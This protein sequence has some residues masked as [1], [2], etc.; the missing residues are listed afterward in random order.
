M[1]ADTST[2][3][4]ETY[5][6]LWVS[7]FFHDFPHV[8]FTF[9]IV[10]STFDPNSDVYRQSLLFWALVPVAI[11][12]LLWLV[13][14]IYFIFRC[15]QG[16]RKSKGRPSVCQG[17]AD[18]TSY[19]HWLVSIVLG[20]VGFG[21]YENENAHHGI[22]DV[23]DSRDDVNDVLQSASNR[24]DTLKIL[25][26]DVL[27][28][29][30]GSLET[31]ANN[32]TNASVRAL[33]VRL[34]SDIRQKTYD[35]RGYLD[36]VRVEEARDSSLDTIFDYEYFRWMITIVIFCLYIFILLL[37][38]VGL[39][40]RSKG[41]LI[42]S[43]AVAVVCSLFIWLATGVYT[44]LSVAAGDLCMDPDT[45]FIRI[46][47]GSTAEVAVTAYIRC[48]DPNQ[49]YKQIIDNAT[50][51]V[52]QAGVSLNETVRLARPYNIS[53]LDK[54]VA[55]VNSDLL[56]ARGNL[57][58]LMA[59]VGTCETLHHYYISGVESACTDTISA[60]A[61]LA[62]VC[63]LVATLC[64]VIIFC[65]SC[66]WRQYAKKRLQSEYI[67]V[68]DKDPFLPRPPPY[69]TDYGTMGQSG[70]QPW[71]G[72]VSLQHPNGSSSSDDQVMTLIY[73]H[74]YPADDSPPPAYHPGKFVQRYAESGPTPS[75][76]R[77]YSMK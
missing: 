65:I 24:I 33:A 54:P 28:V 29:L 34:I 62:V 58:D 30:S 32:I 11:C 42:T 40:L 74:P 60:T 21:F 43:A 76:A 17:L 56:Y 67:N 25:A 2:S 20:L 41:T 8:D 70:P 66:L 14:L 4:Q 13:F 48:T 53:G 57:S 63:C 1:A 3:V 9:K 64:T 31:A 51:A 38:L 19:F 59:T 55:D 46:A 49:P 15:C 50:A 5:E 75:S 61:L 39:L 37:S 27:S 71:T 45:Y 69:E 7:E 36:K 16:N 77:A 22:E 35:A 10:N 72:R 6:K 18:R 12:F 26:D 68:D 44:G 23:K 47:H 52:T 73:Q